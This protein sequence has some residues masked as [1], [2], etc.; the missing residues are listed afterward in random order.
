MRKLRN[1]C[2]GVDEGSVV[3]FSD[4]EDGGEMWT[5]SGPRQRR[6]PVRFAEAFK[7]LPSVHLSMAM[8]DID[9]KSGQRADLSPEAITEEGFDIV[10]KTWGDTRVA[11]VRADWM[12]IGEVAHEDDWELY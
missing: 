11:R 10:F 12:A 8:W 1:Y 9:Q 4:Y 7:S 6:V 3:L 5:G 2:I